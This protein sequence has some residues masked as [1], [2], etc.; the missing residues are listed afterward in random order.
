VKH[1]RPKARSQ[2]GFTL[3]EVILAL[4]IFAL[5]GAI[6]HGAFSL[7]HGA[8]EKA[9]SSFDEN[10]RLR[11]LADLLGGYIRSSYA[12]RSSPQDPAIFYSGEESWLVFVSSIS[13]AMGGRGMAKIHLTWE[14]TRE[15]EGVLS[16]EEETPVRLETETVGGGYRTGIVLRDRVKDFRLAYLDSQGEQ[17]VW[18]E[19]WDGRERRVLPRA[20][21]ISYRGKGGREIQWVFP[22]MVSVLAP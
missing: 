1:R 12:Y 20:V 10:Q 19:R 3:I 15:N 2:V 18:A 21:R 17:E 6:L 11:S 8:V 5:M 22:V 14:A 7:G 9:Q 13:M 16:L 4:A